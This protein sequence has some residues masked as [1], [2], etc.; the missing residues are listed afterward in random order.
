MTT[1][2]LPEPVVGAL[3]FFGPDPGGSRSPNIVR[4]VRGL[5][6][7]VRE[8]NSG[9]LVELL[10]TEWMSAH[11]MCADT[12]RIIR[13]GNFSKDDLLGRIRVMT[14]AY[15]LYSKNGKRRG[16]EGS[17]SLSDVG[18][19]SLPALAGSARKTMPESDTVDKLWNKPVDGGSG[20]S[21]DGLTFSALPDLLAGSRRSASA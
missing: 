7:V 12:D 6:V 14:A 11:E 17:P 1:Q 19:A 5:V 20:D 13:A 16:N 10:R 15:D 4:E 8:V 18:D 9:A 3:G 21:L 2:S